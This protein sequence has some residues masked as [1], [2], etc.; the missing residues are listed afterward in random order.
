MVIEADWKIVRLVTFLN[1]ILFEWKRYRIE[2]RPNRIRSERK[3]I[4][5]DPT[6]NLFQHAQRGGVAI[7]P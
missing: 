4:I 5:G 7:C 6:W 1:R 2:W 3:T